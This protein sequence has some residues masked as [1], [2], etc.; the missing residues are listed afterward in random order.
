M[1][2]L[3]LIA[4]LFVSTTLIAQETID[5]TQFQTP[6]KQQGQRGTCT[7]FG[8][9][10]M[11]EV[12]PGLPANVSEQYLYGGLKVSQDDKPFQEGDQLINY[13]QSLKQFGIVHEDILPYNPYAIDWES[14]DDEL[15]RLI[16]GAQIGGVGMYVAANHA[17]YGV[18]EEDMLYYNQDN[19]RNPEVLKNLLR[20][21]HKAVAV[22]YGIHIPTWMNYSDY[23]TAIEPK[24]NVELNGSVYTLKQ[25]QRLYNGDLIRDALDEKVPAYFDDVYRIDPETGDSISNY[26][27]H[28]VTV[29]GYDAEGFI[30]KNSWGTDWGQNGYGRVSY[31]MHRIL[32][33][34]MMAIKKA[35]LYQAPNQV[36]LSANIDIRLKS[37]LSSVNN[38]NA[39]QI[40]LFVPDRLA[41]AQYAT[42]TYKVYDSEGNL[43]TEKYTLGN[44]S[45]NR[46]SF[47]NTSSA[48]APFSDTLP[49]PDV[50]F[51][52]GEMTIVATLSDGA[53]EITK[54]FRGVTYST[55]EYKA[56]AIPFSIYN[57]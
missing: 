13:I 6:V 28:V 23:S 45:I 9:G 47:N 2:V 26:G 11:L 27:G 56:S 1:R 7:A 39:Y 34:E 55:D 15:V 25:A 50:L 37:S 21:G 32:V 29:V 33:N 44:T 20:N 4:A 5:Y 8:V 53:S 49:P 14:A 52:K 12:L 17:K 3:F 22:S 10:A 24:V 16:R 18:A 40:S 57:R 38:K 41:D 35:T 54:T 30:I 42:V 51:R 19:S 31:D 48:V 36:P 43:L 46:K